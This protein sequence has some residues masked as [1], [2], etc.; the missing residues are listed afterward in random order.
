[1][2]KVQNPVECR[3]Y[4]TVLL[5]G[6]GTKVEMAERLAMLG[7]RGWPGAGRGSRM[8]KCLNGSSDARGRRRVYRGAAGSGSCARSMEQKGGLG[9]E[10]SVSIEACE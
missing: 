9:R 3:Y 2:R 10:R 7:A 5:Q 1:M 4:R 8:R 6:G